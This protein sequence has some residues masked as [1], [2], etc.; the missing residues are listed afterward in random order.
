M[1]GGQL[2]VWARMGLPPKL[3]AFFRANVL[4]LATLV[5]VII[6]VTIGAILN[7]YNAESPDDTDGWTPRQ[8]MHVKF[9]GDLFLR[10]L[11]GIIIPLIVPSLIASVGSLDLSLSGKVGGRAIAYYVVTTILAVILGIVLV[12]SVS[13]SHSCM[14]KLPDYELSF[15]IRPGVG[16][17]SEAQPKTEGNERHVLTEDTMMDLIRNCFPPNIVQALLQQYSTVL[18]EPEANITQRNG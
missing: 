2:D 6:G 10:M 9:I 15:Q 1:A 11:K 16:A 5:G 18:D 13:L 4:T 3:A 7:S 12:T 14:L 8:V 17:Q